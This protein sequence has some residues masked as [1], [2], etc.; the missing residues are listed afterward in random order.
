VFTRFF[1]TDRIRFAACSFT[2]PDNT[3]TDAVPAL[4]GY[5][6]STQAANENCISRVYIGFH[7]RHA[8][9]EGTGHGRRIANHAFSHHL[10]PTHH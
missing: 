10:R 3:C 6:T 8:A 4:R 2:L 9:T 1:G 5:R 7:F